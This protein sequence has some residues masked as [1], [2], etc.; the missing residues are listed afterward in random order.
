MPHLD[1][2]LWKGPNMNGPSEAECAKILSKYPTAFSVGFA[3]PKEDAP[4]V[5]ELTPHIQ[6]P[7]KIKSLV[8]TLSEFKD[9]SLVFHFMNYPDGF[10]LDDRQPYTVLKQGNENIVLAYIHGRLPTFIKNDKRSAAYHFATDYI[11]PMLADYW[12][13][14]KGNL[15]IMKKL[16]DANATHRQLKSLLGEG[17]VCFQMRDGD[18]LSID[19]NAVPFKTEYG[20]ITDKCESI[21]K[22][23]PKPVEE[24][25]K[26]GIVE[27]ESV[28]EPDEAPGADQSVDEPDEV[29]IETKKLDDQLKKSAPKSETAIAAQLQKLPEHCEMRNGNQVWFVPPHNMHGNQLKKQ[30][31]GRVAGFLPDGRS[32]DEYGEIYGHWKQDRPAVRLQSK[33]LKGVNL[34]ALVDLGRAKPVE[35][36]PAVAQATP[37]PVTNAQQHDGSAF[38]VDPKIIAKMA[39]TLKQ[40][41]VLRILD[42]YGKQIV[43]PNAIASMVETKQPSF[44][45]INGLDLDKTAMWTVDFMLDVIPDIQQM[46]LFAASWKNQA[47][48]RYSEDEKK[49]LV[50]KLSPIKKEQP[51][52]KQRRPGIAA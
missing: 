33:K 39:E 24:A 14:S 28:D 40:P 13:D 48:K 41:K 19:A 49:A 25:R 42:E 47:L 35:T 17:H 30:G 15:E 43:S 29:E 11:T 7:P 44:S 4:K 34:V 5:M 18:I 26:P 38:I 45:E 52:A 37:A 20:W 8:K 46:A 36:K 31:Y 2:T 51:A 3:Y 22:P 6:M 1:M 9:A 50:Q 10:E 16:M 12:H 32:K 23:T 27:D 21:V